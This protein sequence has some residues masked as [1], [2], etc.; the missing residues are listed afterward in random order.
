MDYDLKELL[1]KMGV[2]DVAETGSV[3]WHYMDTRDQ[4]VGGF[5]DVRLDNSG[6]GLT[7]ELRHWKKDFENDE[8]EIQS[9]HTESFLLT[10]RRLGDS[11]LFRITG[12][13]FDGTEYNADDAAMIELGCGIF[14]A[15]AVEINT[16][17]VEQRFKA[18]EKEMD[19][20]PSSTED[21]KKRFQA[22][23]EEKAQEMWGIVVPFQ[24]RKD[25][26]IQRI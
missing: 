3:K 26:P 12:I 1:H 6:R 24:P 20:L 14:H 25:A 21:L 16:L 15:R 10:A 17:M 2:P 23:L 4:D 18:L 7:V 22:T 5:A 8:G 11:D 13:S 9:R 19:A